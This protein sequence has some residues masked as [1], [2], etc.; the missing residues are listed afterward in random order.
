MT[1]AGYPD[2]EISFPILLSS[3]LPTAAAAQHATRAQDQWKKIWPKINVTLQPPADSAT[4]NKLQ[5]TNDFTVISYT[6][7]SFPDPA[8]ELAAQYHTPTGLLG[9]RNYGH[10][11]NADAGA[12]IEKV[13]ATIDVNA[14]KQI[15]LDFQKQYFDEWMPVIQ[16]HMQPDRYFVGPHFGN[17]QNL[18]GTWWFINFRLA[19]AAEYFSHV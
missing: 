10:F 15:L 17:F 19:T 12:M 8:L 5:S 13:L 4:F 1:A 2:G 11:K 18:L 7:T 14:R 6:N 16:L 9:S 3:N